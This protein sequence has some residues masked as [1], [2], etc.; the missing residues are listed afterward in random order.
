MNNINTRFYILLVILLGIFTYSLSLFNKISQCSLVFVFLAVTANIISE[1][2]GRKKAWIAVTLCI[3]VSFCLLWDF[4]Y[5]I[6]GR[7]I[8]GIILVSF[9]SILFSTYCSTS[10]F[11]QLKS[12]CS[13]NTRNFAGLMMGAVVDGIV[14]SGFFVNIFSTS[15]VLSMFLKEVLFKCAYSLTVYICIFLGSF[16]VQKVYCNNRA[17]RE[18]KNFWVKNTAEYCKNLG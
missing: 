18:L 6:H 14:M 15:R 12:T 4:N 3:I 17:T 9:V 10:V 7:V 13:L 8:N 1:L 5:Y 11:V 2:Y 16:L